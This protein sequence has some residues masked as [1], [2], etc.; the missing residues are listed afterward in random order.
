[1]RV[2]ELP[3][4]AQVFRLARASRIIYGVMAPLLLLFGVGQPAL[5]IA[6]LIGAGGLSS[7]IGWFVALIIGFQGLGGVAMALTACRLFGHTRTR[8]ILADAGVTYDTFW[9]TR[10]TDWANIA[11]IGPTTLGFSAVDAFLLHRPATLQL[12]WYGFP[13]LRLLPRTAIPITGFS[14]SWWDGPLAEAIRRYAPHL[15]A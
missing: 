3:A 1:M 10:H 15:G 2:A 13:F 4:Q 14:R 12:R 9:E 8:L 5:G 11:Q 6:Q 7:G